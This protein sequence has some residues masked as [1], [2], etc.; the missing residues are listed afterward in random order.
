MLT[1]CKEHSDC[2]VVSDYHGCPFCDKEGEFSDLEDKI[3]EVEMELSDT[4]SQ[5]R[6][7]EV[8][9]DDLR[10]EVASLEARVQELEGGPEAP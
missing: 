6:E 7:A 4:E 1:T 5:L 3:E 8:T 10:D 9:I 2:I